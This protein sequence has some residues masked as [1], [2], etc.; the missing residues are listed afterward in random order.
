MISLK[1][2]NA[3][4]K[5]VKDIKECGEDYRKS[6]MEHLRVTIIEGTFLEFFVR[7]GTAI[8]IAIL[9]WRCAYGYVDEGWLIIAFF[10]IGATFSPMITLISA[11][12]LGFQGVSGSYSI[13]EFLQ[14]ES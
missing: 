10:S 11:W 5:Y 4:K 13:N 7:V 2:F 6:I 3:D 9:G 8:T 1:A 14:I 12:H